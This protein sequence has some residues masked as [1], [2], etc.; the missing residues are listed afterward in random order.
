MM[1]DSTEFFLEKIHN[2]VLLLIKLINL[3]NLT[4]KRQLRNLWMKW[5]Y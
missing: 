4:T 5:N 1:C 3:L 2:A